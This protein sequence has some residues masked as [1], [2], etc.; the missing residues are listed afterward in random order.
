LTDRLETHQQAFVLLLGHRRYLVHVVASHVL[1]SFEFDGQKLFGDHIQ[2][3]AIRERVLFIGT[4]FSI[5]YT[6]MYSPAGAASPIVAAR[7]FLDT[8]LPLGAVPR[9][10]GV[11]E[12][13]GWVFLKTRPRFTAQAKH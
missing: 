5:L 4:Q 12:G 1:C 13:G 7:T 9:E 6:S 8:A 3:D 2:A 11:W 10:T